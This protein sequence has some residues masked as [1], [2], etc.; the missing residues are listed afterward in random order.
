M[1]RIDNIDESVKSKSRKYSLKLKDDQE[2][3]GDIE[4]NNVNTE[5]QAKGTFLVSDDCLKISIIE[6]NYNENYLK[7][8]IINDLLDSNIAVNN[9]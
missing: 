5:K 8:T 1:I 2:N 7:N 3:Y 4:I 9:I 6:S